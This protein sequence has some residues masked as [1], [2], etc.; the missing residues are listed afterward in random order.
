MKMKG[1]LSMV[2]LLRNL[3]W[4]PSLDKRCVL[5]ESGSESE[6]EIEQQIRCSLHPSGAYVPEG[7]QA[8]ENGD[9]ILFQSDV[10]SEA[11]EGKNNSGRAGQVVSDAVRGYFSKEVTV[12]D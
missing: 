5:S 6:L 10:Y 2:L 8:T 7:N 3:H 1:W 12:I 4:S 9:M 11:K